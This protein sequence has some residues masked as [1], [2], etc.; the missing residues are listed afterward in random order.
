MVASK[1]V[2]AVLSLLEHEH[3]QFRAGKIQGLNLQPL[4]DAKKTTKNL[5]NKEADIGL[6][7]E[8]KESRRT[9]V[10]QTIDKIAMLKTKQIYR[11][12]TGD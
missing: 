6:T 11:H 5:L 10:L 1:P 4:K 12:L 7:S 2:Y 8:L 9:R 3:D